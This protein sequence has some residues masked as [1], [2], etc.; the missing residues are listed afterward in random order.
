MLKFVVGV[1]EVRFYSNA[2]GSTGHSIVCATLDVIQVQVVKG[3]KVLHHL[4]VFLSLG[5]Q[6]SELSVGR[7]A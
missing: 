7:S 3:F 1:A 6:W 4:N 5:E 2:A